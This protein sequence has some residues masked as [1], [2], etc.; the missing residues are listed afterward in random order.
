MA[1]WNETNCPLLVMAILN[2]KYL[3]SIKHIHVLLYWECYIFHFFWIY[4]LPNIHFQWKLKSEKSALTLRIRKSK[5]NKFDVFLSIAYFENFCFPQVL[6]LISLSFI[7]GCLEMNLLPEV[8]VIL[9]WIVVTVR[10]QQW[11]MMLFF[12]CV[13]LY[14]IGSLTMCCIFSNYI[15]CVFFVFYLLCPKRER[16]IFKIYALQTRV[17]YYSNFVY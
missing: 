16:C 17:Q 13:W 5:S 4:L 12:G 10:W 3:D 9:V 15:S 8:N 11:R 6:H 1:I 2:L 14:E 7:N